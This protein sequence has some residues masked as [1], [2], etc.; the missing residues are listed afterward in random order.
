MFQAVILMFAA[1]SMIPAGDLCG[2][3]LTGSGL[4]T[5][6]FVAWSRFSIGAALILPFVPRRAFTLLG[7]WRLWLRAGLL[8][9]GIFSIQMALVTE[10][11]ANVF[12]AFF[13][14]PV[15]SY[16]L[17]VL[18]LREQATVPRSLLMALGF[19]GVLMVVR[20]GFG[21]SLNLLWAVLAGC[22]YGGFLT[23]SRWLAGVGSPLE[24]SLTQLLLSACL[25]LP[26][27][28][29]S[30]PEF[31]APTAALT[32]GSAAFSMLGNLLLLF[33]YGRVQAV[34]L[35]P[36]VY[37]QLVAAVGLGW[38]VFRQLPDAWTWAGLAV[39]LSAGLASALLRR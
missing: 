15:I 21:G 24:L 32:V 18:L 23:S 26:L 14:G 37:F 8:T 31:S 27:G 13:I 35:A 29:A 3:L 38:A 2:K 16:V 12:A 33:A 28:L 20:P 5:P 7:D 25:M 4:A 9:G 22:F 10:P 34:K 11:L 17:S 39:V 6:A 30:L 1:M 36:M 19:L